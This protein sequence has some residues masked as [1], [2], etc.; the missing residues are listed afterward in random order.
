MT[1]PLKSAFSTWKIA[2][3]I[4][5]GLL[6]SSWMV[7][8]AISK[9]NFVKVAEGKGTHSWVDSNKNSEIDIHNSEDFKVD[10]NGN[11]TQETVSN[12]LNQIEWTNSIW[13]W[14]IG[15]LL[16][17]IG[18]DFFYMLHR[19]DITRLA[20]ECRVSFFCLC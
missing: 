7:Y 18:R 5:I 1:S 16:F 2:L 3:A 19:M 20:R 12:A 9:V 10:A 13:W 6:I 15:A 14:L 4:G 17:M 8:R 11:Y